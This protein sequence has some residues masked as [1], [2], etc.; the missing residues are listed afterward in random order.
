MTR[1][2]AAGSPHRSARTAATLGD[3]SEYRGDDGLT[4]DELRAWHRRRLRVLAEPGPMCS[5]SRR[6]TRLAEIEAVVRRTRRNRR[7]G[8]DQRRRST[9]ARCAPANRCTT[10]SRS[11]HR[12]PESSRRRELLRGARGRRRARRSRATARDLPLIAYPNSGEVWDGA[13]RAWTGDAATARRRSSHEWVAHGGGAIGGC[14]RIGPD[15]SSPRSPTRGRDDRHARPR[16]LAA[17]RSGTTRFRR[18]PR[19]ARAP[20]RRSWMPTSPSS[21]AA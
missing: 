11:R 12:A 21:A 19:A 5:P 10:R 16:L 17:C 6:I 3:G 13:A 1:R 14:C 2:P 8:L 7:S 15:R 18:A 4:V 20:R 9:A